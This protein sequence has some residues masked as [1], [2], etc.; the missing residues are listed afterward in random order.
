MKTL[1]Y[2]Q[3]TEEPTPKKKKYKVDPMQDHLRDKEDRQ[4][5]EPLQVFYKNYDLYDTD[6]VD[7]PAKQGPGTGLYQHMNEYKSVADFKKKKRKKKM[8]ERRAAFLFILSKTDVN[9][10]ITPEDEIANPLIPYAP[11]EPAQIGVL[12][13]IYPKSDLEDHP[14]GNL[15][16]GI[17]ETHLVDDK[18]KNEEK[19]KKVSAK[20]KK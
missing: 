3:G 17:M 11:A 5:K 9:K 18:E 1:G 19:D 4:V 12:D 20:K 8:Q 13:G 15:Y 2:Y 16:Y 7:G 6:G 10:I 14:V